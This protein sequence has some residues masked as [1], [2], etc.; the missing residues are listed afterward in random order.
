LH[1]AT[2]S[3]Q[4]IDLRFKLPGSDLLRMT[5]LNSQSSLSSEPSSEPSVSSKELIGTS[6]RPPLG[7]RT[8]ALVEAAKGFLAWAAGCGL[9]S[10]RHTDLHAATD[11]FLLRHGID[12]ERPYTRLAIESVARATHSHPHE[13]IGFALVYGAIRLA[14]AYG[15]WRAKHWAEWFA[16]ISASIYLPLELQH[17]FL[18]PGLLSGG[19]IILNL[20]L[21][22]Y[23]AKLLLRQRAQRH[24]K[25]NPPLLP[26]QRL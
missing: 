17:C 18:R 25:E 6:A 19:I 15:L 10:L 21:I 26:Q 4:R 24:A 7:L 5:K 3:F 9:L 11:A 8:F 23:L 13:I 2:A 12:P 16:L 20:I 14:E 1:P 22:F